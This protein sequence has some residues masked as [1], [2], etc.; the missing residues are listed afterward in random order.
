M[1]TLQL[2][3]KQTKT[4]PGV[5]F[6]S[7]SERR[8]QA[9]VGKCVPGSVSVNNENWPCQRMIPKDGPLQQTHTYRQIQKKKKKNG[10]MK[11]KGS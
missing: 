9:D 2:L 10:E 11:K 3:M 7:R 4:S 8:N 1:K 6:I 5:A